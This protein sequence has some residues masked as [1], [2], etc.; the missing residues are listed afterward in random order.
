MRKFLTVTGLC[1]TLAA[2]ATNPVSG[3]RE[4]ALMSEAQEISIGRE[5]HPKVLQQY[6]QYEDP[7]LQAYVQGVG[8]KLA[9]H[10]HRS[11]LIYRFTVVDSTDINAFALPGGY[12]YITRGLLAYLGSEAEMAGVLG[13]EIGHV[14]ARH[15]VRQYTA[16]TAAQLGM[17]LGSIFV[18]GLGSNVGQN[19]MGVLGQAML[20]GYGR[21]HELESDGLGAEYLARAGYDPQ[22]ILDV[23]RTL[24]AQGDYAAAQAKA[25]GRQPQSYHGLFA[26]H[27]DED[28]RLKEVLTK[29]SF[30]APDKPAD[31]GRQAF[32]KHIDGLVFGDSAAQGIRRG[33]RFYHRDLDFALEFPAGWR[34]ENRPDRL[35]A[36][37]PGGKA[38]AQLTSQ[39]LNQRETP[40]E[41]MIR[42]LGIKNPAGEEI[43]PGGLPGYTAPLKIQGRPGR[44]SVIFHRN[45]AYVLASVA[46]DGADSQAVDAAMRQTAL[47]FHPLRDDEKA[48]AEPLRLRLKPAV[49][50]DTYARLAQGSRLPGDAQ[51]QLRLL[52]GHYPQ[53]E[54]KP[55]D[56]LKI[57]E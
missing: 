7:A 51:A 32:L 37:A 48:L 22:A 40:R 34:L 3:R 43:S 54:P 13:H 33:N 8:E 35:L 18:P 6:G 15:A 24:K 31:N 10:S 12:I 27:P 38:Q 36:V 41:F 49:A 23:L 9:A 2:C 55:G 4:M 29:A 44:V 56:I 21:E 20:S 5:M 26:S 16:A 17:T 47:G 45:Q 30:L 53:G 50:G 14:T 25:E 39:D 52:N 11:N 28:T 46:L 19:V 42:R 57:V 1:L